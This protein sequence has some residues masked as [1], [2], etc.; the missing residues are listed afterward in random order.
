MTG[1]ELHCQQR[2]HAPITALERALP[3][4]LFLSMLWFQ[5]VGVCLQIR[6]QG[7]RRHSSEQPKLPVD[8]DSPPRNLTI[9]RKSLLGAQSTGRKKQ[10]KSTSGSFFQKTF[11]RE[12]E[13]ASLHTH[14]AFTHLH[15]S[16]SSEGTCHCITSPRVT[17]KR[18]LPS[19]LFKQ[20]A[21]QCRPVLPRA[22]VPEEKMIILQE[23][24]TSWPGG[25]PSTAT[26]PS[27]A[28]L[29]GTASPWVNH[30]KGWQWLGCCTCHRSV[31][32][33]PHLNILKHGPSLCSFPRGVTGPPSPQSSPAA[34]QTHHNPKP[35]DHR[36]L[37]GSCHP[38]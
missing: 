4:S 24:C 16:Q 14:Q 21:S 35:Q 31:T 32:P 30:S 26:A 19:S 38:I 13:Q 18:H 17:C 5:P 22:T 28:L 36:W 7:K 11:F 27:P 15:C 9:P 1:T 25:L 6:S 12:R 34:P 2:A 37:S 23:G 10:Q 20:G 33:C 3:G 8:L 29:Q